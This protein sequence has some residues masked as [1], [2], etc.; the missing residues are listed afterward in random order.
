VLLAG[1]GVLAMAVTASP[2]H[3]VDLARMTGDLERGQW[4]LK[5]MVLDLMR[6]QRPR[7]G[8]GPPA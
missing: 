8:D 7:G 4:T 6:A 2:Y 3:A 5:G 1:T